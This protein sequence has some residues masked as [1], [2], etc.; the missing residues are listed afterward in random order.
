MTNPADL[1]RQLLLDQL[2][3][4]ARQIEARKTGIYLLEDRQRR[5][6]EQ[7]RASGWTAPKP[8]RPAQSRLSMPK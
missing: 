1:Q 7:L 2:A 6:R 5:V 8:E 3:E 4:I